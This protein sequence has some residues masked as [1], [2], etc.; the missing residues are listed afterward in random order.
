MTTSAPR[1]EHRARG[2]GRGG[3]RGA[4]G[5]RGRRRPTPPSRAAEPEARPLAERRA[6][7]SRLDETRA[8]RARRRGRRVPRARAAHAGRLRELPQADGARRAR[9]RGARHGSPGARSCCPRWTT[10]SARWRPSRR[11]ARTR[12]HHLTQGI[13][14]VQSELSAALARTGIEGY[15][16]QGE[17]FDPNQHE[18]VAQQPVEGAE[19]GTIVEVLPARLPPQRRGAAARAGG[20]GR[21]GRA[22]MPRRTTTRCSAST[23]R[24]RRPRSRRPTASSRASTTRTATPATRR[25]RRASSRSRRPTTSSATPRS[26]SSTTAAGSNPF[27]A[28]RRAAAGSRARGGF[29]TGGV[30]RHPL[31][32]LRPGGA[33]RRPG[34]GG[35]RARAPSAAAT[36]RPRSRSAS[37]RR[38]TGAQ[39]PLVGAD[40]I[41]RCPTCSGTGA[42]PGTRADRLPALP[43]PRD[44]DP[45]P[46]P[47]LDLPAVL[48]LRRRRHGHRGP[49]PDLPAATG[50]T[51]TVKRYRVNIPAGVRDGSRMRLAGKGEPGRNG[52]PPGDLYVITRVQASPVFARKG[53]HVEVEVPLT[54]PEALRGAEVEVPDARTAARRCASRRAPSPARVQRLR[55]E[56]PP[57]ARQG[58]ARRHPLPL[59][60]RPPR[61]S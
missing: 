7:A 46:G 60:A 27:S 13:R 41:E 49:V 50:A 14:L 44:R 26:A 21:L 38:S 52:G 16:P 36:S 1:S 53:D 15:A 28:G 30:R 57:A 47:V 35:P 32:P 18:A 56:G 12:E 43:G 22:A 2:D 61:R 51:R 58:R 29:D 42:K 40:V 24:R 3:R 6:R 34:H 54:I 55:G 25:P 10:S 19:P 45:G 5:R 33:R 17:R 37:T 39:V 4:P 8:A 11:P 23:A 31:R 48:A 20:G 59:R 9:G